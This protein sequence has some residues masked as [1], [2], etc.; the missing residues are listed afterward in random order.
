MRSIGERCTAA[1]RAPRSKGRLSVIRQPACTARRMSIGVMPL[2][3]RPTASPGYGLSLARRTN[4]NTAGAGSGPRSRSISARVKL[5]RGSASSSTAAEEVATV[6]IASS[7][8]Q[9]LASWMWIAS[10]R[11]GLATRMRSPCRVVMVRP[12]DLGYVQRQARGVPEWGVLLPVVCAPHRG[13]GRGLGSGLGRCLSPARS[14]PSGRAILPGRLFVQVG[15]NV[16][17]ECLGRR[18]R[19][20]HA[21]ISPAEWRKP[22]PGDFGSVE[23]PY[24]GFSLRI[25]RCDFCK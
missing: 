10:L 6:S 7:V 14:C 24:S 9:G 19:K 21:G 18:I 4:W 11:C 1:P 3:I 2:P 22:C 25:G 17:G 13:G 12:L 15:E 20:G 23:S 16:T 8:S 5:C